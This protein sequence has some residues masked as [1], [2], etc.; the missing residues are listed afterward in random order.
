MSHTVPH[1]PHPHWCELHS[2]RHKVR[3]H[4]HHVAPYG[5]EGTVHVVQRFQ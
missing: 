2:G 1:R 5:V 3:C 4:G